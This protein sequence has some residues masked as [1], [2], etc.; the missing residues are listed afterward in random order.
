MCDVCKAR[1]QHYAMAMAVCQA[2]WDFI[3][4]PDGTH[5]YAPGRLRG[6]TDKVHELRQFELATEQQWP[7]SVA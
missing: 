7:I 1:E 6:L 5:V 2:A 3:N 4:P